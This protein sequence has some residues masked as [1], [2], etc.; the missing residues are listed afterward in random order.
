MTE[1]LG[2]EEILAQSIEASAGSIVEGTVVSQTQTHLL[3]DVGL[4]QEATLLLKEFPGP[5]PATGEKIPVLIIRMRGAE[6]RPIVSWKQARERTNWDKITASYQNKES[7]EGRIVKRIKGGVQVDIGLDAFMPASQIDEKPVPKPE[8]W[9]GKTVRVLVLE[10]DRA[11]SN[12]LVSRRRVLEQE[13]KVKKEAVL[14]TLKEGQ[15]YKGK[16]TGITNFGAFIDIGGAEG[17]LHVSDMAWTKVENP[18][19]IFKVGEEI[20]VKVLKFDANAQKFALGRKQ[21]LPHPW[22]GIESKYP[23]G[24]TI[25]GKVSAFASFGAFIEVVPGIEGM[26][27][28]TEFSWINKPKSPKDMFKLGQEVEV[29]VIG[30]TRNQEKM[31]LS[32][33]RMQSNPWEEAFK[34]YP[35]KSKIEVTVTH[36][37]PF[38]AFVKTPLGIEG[39]VKIQDL[40]WT[41]RIE[42]PHKVLKEGQTLKVVVLEV[43]VANE[44]MS[45]GIKQL[46]PD[47]IGSMRIGTSVK[48]KVTKITDFGLFVKL[49]SGLEGLVRSSEIKLDRS[50][51]GGS[52]EE[53]RSK[54]EPIKSFSVGEDVSA[55]V[56][57]INKKERKIDLSIRRYEKNQEK[58]LLRKYSSNTGRPTLGETT[59]WMEDSGPKE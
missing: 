32:L 51:F 16:I 12:V 40:S 10:M 29:K 41:E 55:S 13:K 49:D 28:I 38:G 43:D 57:K 50:M 4:K 19:K 9:V 54:D 5:I 37:A 18:N 30:L 58:E 31:S 11:K 42:H 44:K 14:K 47:P 2:M 36:L 23:I 1:E 21:L 15:V 45:L 33:K 6:G 22:D 17:L 20:E 46:T 53:H 25:K 27:H 34:K 26:V 8:D 52:K 24:C 39:L 59:G 56:I 3:V 48:G 7:V 35:P